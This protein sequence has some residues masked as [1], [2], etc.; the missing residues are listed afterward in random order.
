MNIFKANAVAKYFFIC[1]FLSIYLNRKICV[2]FGDVESIIVEGGLK[3]SVYRVGELL[4]ALKS[5]RQKIKN[6]NNVKI[7]INK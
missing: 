4:Y 3:K 6:E 1:I 2:V 5:N 7:N